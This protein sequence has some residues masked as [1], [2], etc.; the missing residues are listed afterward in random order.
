MEETVILAECAPSAG[1][2]QD[3]RFPMMKVPSLV[4]GPWSFA[5]QTFE[6]FAAVSWLACLDR[7]QTTN[8]GFSV[9]ALP[10]LS[11]FPE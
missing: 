2:T 5:G 4:V 6:C 10:T 1:L 3:T 7:R 9:C 8:G 11:V